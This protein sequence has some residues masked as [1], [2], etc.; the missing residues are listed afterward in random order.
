MLVIKKNNLYT[1]SFDH[2]S[3]K[4]VELI[5]NFKNDYEQ[6]VSR[7]KIGDGEMNAYIC[8]VSEIDLNVIK[9]RF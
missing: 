8:R 2:N 4:I 7:G 9:N 1:N 3:D 5:N 6:E